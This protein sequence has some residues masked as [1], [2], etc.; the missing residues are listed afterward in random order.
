MSINSGG[1][2][3][4]AVRELERIVEELERGDVSLDRSV[5]LYNRGREL[6]KYCY[7]V[8]KG[9]T[10]KIESLGEEDIE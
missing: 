8:I 10:L 1:R 3:E 9:V 2:F 4:E 7:E 6:H 5:E